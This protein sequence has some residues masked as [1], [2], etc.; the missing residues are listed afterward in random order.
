MSTSVPNE[1]IIWVLV[2]SGVWFFKDFLWVLR[3]PVNWK[4]RGGEGPDIK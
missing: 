2:D 1:N 3:V 4:K